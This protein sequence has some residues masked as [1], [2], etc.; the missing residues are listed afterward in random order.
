M[1]MYENSFNVL[2]YSLRS[3]L[4]HLSRYLFKVFHVVQ[5]GKNVHEINEVFSKYYYE[6]SQRCVCVCVCM[7][8]CAC[9]YMCVRSFIS[10]II[11][12]KNYSPKLC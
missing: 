5:L 8:V 10:F 1:L 7:Y 12:L 3:Y 4:I 11:P 6:E 9:V 2:Y